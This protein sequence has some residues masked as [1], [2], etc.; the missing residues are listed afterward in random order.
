MHPVLQQRHVHP[1]RWLVVIV[2][3][4]AL[5]GADLRAPQSASAAVG[6]PVT[7]QDH[8]YSTAVTKPNADKPQSKLWYHDGAWW[9][10]MVEAGG[11]R[12]TVHEL[13]ADHT[14]R[15]TGALIDSRTN[16]TAD[17]LWSSADDKLFTA[18]RVSGADLQVN[19]LSYHSA[20]RSWTVDAGFPVTI[21]SGGGSESATL[22]RD[23]LGRLWVT[24]T[25]GSRVWVAHST[26]SSG[27]SFGAPFQPNVPDTVVSADDLSALISFGSSIG[28]M[29]SDQQSGAFRFA[30]HD[31]ADTDD[32]WR[33]ETALAGPGLTDDHINLKQ[34]TG[35]PQ[36]RIFAAV[37]TSA[38]DVVGALP[39]DTLVAVLSRTPG[40]GG[41]G[42]WSMAPA[43]TIADDHTR[44]IL[45]IDATNKELYFLA[46]AP[47]GGGDIYY[48][49]APLSDV[50]FPAGRGARFVD[51]PFSVNDASGAKD[52]VT[53][54]SGMVVVA[55]SDSRR[56]YV[57]AEMELSGSG[58]TVPPTASTVP[59]AG[60]T[61]VG[62]DAN[63]TATFDEAVQGVSGS[64]FTL[65]DAATGAAVAGSVT[66][67][68]STRVATL[69]PGASL[70]A[71]TQYTAT[72]TGGPTAIRDV[73]GNPLAT[74]S[75]TFT[76]AASADSSAPTLSARSPAVNAT[77]VGRTVNVSSV[78]SEAVQ[79]VDA[80]TYTLTDPTGAVVPAVVSRGSTTNQWILN[81]DPTLA[82]STQYRVTLT[83][84]PAAIRDLAGNPLATVTWTFTTVADTTPPTVTTRS[85]A[86]GA[87]NVGT[88]TTNV[89]ATFSE[90][91]QGVDGSTFR[92]VDPAGVAVAAVVSRNGTTNQWILD[93][94]LALARDT[95]YTATLT[96]G[97]TAIRDLANNPLAS[98]AWS[99]TTG[100]PP[101]VSS[102]SPAVNATGVSVATTVTA[103]FSEA[104]LG[105]SGTTFTLTGSN[106]ALVPAT[107]SRNGTTNQWV[108]TPGA[109]LAQSTQ[110]TVRILGGS[111]GVTDL[112]GN[113]LTTV[114][115]SFTTAP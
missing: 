98:V 86:A 93:P 10:S 57:H 109:P 59:A 53:A 77:G 7:Y 113:T 15:N 1:R 95:K 101:V 49:K 40:A 39:T 69:D 37:K 50:R 92:L 73:T 67:N 48:K 114:S 47:E 108:L 43:G 35:D 17:A 26:D 90:A 3:I 81:P 55:T 85:P 25:R 76:T 103:T 46:T 106:G 16:S 74:V 14:W 112:V 66:Y 58:D 8:F 91:V 80:S 87:T 104:V 28:V 20:N 22:D 105:V 13:L 115:W 21:N 29:W 24:Y 23:S 2:A 18:S 19:R 52:S 36:G 51:A 68:T 72:L 70:A 5:A 83:G 84:G 94:D 30:I 82:A 27:A 9:A 41:T 75:W 78:F 111:T 56:Q 31:D 96:G 34:L 6:V 102:R 11:S 60:A 4:A 97:P 89:T 54:A 71:G 33:V 99:F 45:M 64:T 32:V 65:A 100:P 12:V 110:Y 44:P 79:G 38:D 88:L 63:V 107:V 62:A 61:G 42:T